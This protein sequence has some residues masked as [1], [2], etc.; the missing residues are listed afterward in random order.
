MVVFGGTGP[1]GIPQGS[2]YVLDVKTMSWIKGAQPE[3]RQNRTGMACTVAGDN[4]VV[5]GG[6]RTA[7]M[8]V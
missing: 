6:K 5:W 8:D 7:A 3:A 2:I 4:F 1:S